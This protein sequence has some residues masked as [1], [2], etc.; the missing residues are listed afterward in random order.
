MNSKLGS[1]LFPRS[2]SHPYR[3]PDPRRRTLRS[4]PRGGA[5]RDS[6]NHSLN[7]SHQ[8]PPRLKIK[9]VTIGCFLSNGS[10]GIEFIDQDNEIIIV[11][12]KRGLI[13]ILTERQ[14]C[15]KAQYVHLG[16]TVSF[17]DFDDECARKWATFNYNC[18]TVSPVFLLDFLISL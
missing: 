2:G 10:A 1:R 3:R 14:I 9:I 6:S 4:D 8:L 12:D 15:D 11:D 7:R 16:R 18:R 13:N 5:L 17:L